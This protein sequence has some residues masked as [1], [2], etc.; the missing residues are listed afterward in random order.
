MSRRSTVIV[1]LDKT[2][3][4]RGGRLQAGRHRHAADIPAL[5]DQHLR[6]IRRES[7]A[8]LFERLEGWWTDVVIKILSGHRKEPVYGY[9]VSDKL[10]AL[11]EEYRTDNLPITFRNRVPDGKIDVAND[12]RIFGFAR[13]APVRNEP[14]SANAPLLAN[15]SADPGLF[16]F[17]F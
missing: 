12:P 14:W 4:R 13:P 3:E 1:L 5:I 2:L 8:A 16:P 11:A 9:E 6:T 15:R 17:F 10:S 7:R